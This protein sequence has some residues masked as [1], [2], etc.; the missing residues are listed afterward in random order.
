MVGLVL[1][2]KPKNIQELVQFEGTWVGYSW[3]LPVLVYEVT[4]SLSKLTCTGF[5]H[6]IAAVDL[7]DFF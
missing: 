1:S 7:K 4:N 5:K 2:V 6:T 3:Y